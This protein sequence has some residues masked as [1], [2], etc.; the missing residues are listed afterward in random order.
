MRSAAVLRAL[1]LAAV[2]TVLAKLGLMMDAVSGFA[3]L[4]WAPTGL[5]LAALLLLGPEVWPGV[6]LGALAANLWNGAP[7]LVAASIAVGNTLEAVLGAWALRRIPGFRPSLDRL[8]DALALVVLAAV[9]STAVSAT[10][11]TGSLWLGGLVARGAL[12]ATWQAWWLGD[13]IGALVVAPVLLAWIG[14]RSLPRAGMRWLEAVGLGVFAL[15]VSWFVFTGTDS[16]HLA[17]SMET[18]RRPFV[19]FTLFLWSGL[20][21]GIRGTTTTTLVV[22]AVAVTGTAGGQ[23]PFVLDS[24]HASLTYL[25]AFVGIF[26]ATGLVLGATISERAALLERLQEAVKARETFLS[27]ASHELRTPLHALGLQMDLLARQRPDA[28]ALLQGMRR[29]VVRLS[30]LVDQLLEVSRIGVGRLR[31]D[32]EDVD[33]ASVARDAVDRYEPERLR[34]ACDVVVRAPSPVVGAWDRSRLDQIVTN[35][36]SNACK[37][38]AGRPIEIDVLQEGDVAR[39]AVR[40]HG[41]GISENDQKRL[42]ERFE[43]LVSER[44]FGGFGLGLWIVR[45]LVEAHAG[46]VD[47]V[48]RPGEGSTFTVELPMRRAA[49]GA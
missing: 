8:V 42:F 49:E 18:V 2:Y 9:A 26:S 15:A 23:G 24:L 29:Q 31:L 40:D 37:Y 22:T 43:R 14:D 13:A 1:A 28:S 17:R 27:I 34:A 19:L 3:T 30:R 20:R 4:V 10:V 41:I 46:G 7:I 25:Q 16:E 35:L 36:L 5:S 32:I 11:G 45:Q 12:R 21:F 38:G 6:A 48:S 39:L 47:V 44:H 33:L